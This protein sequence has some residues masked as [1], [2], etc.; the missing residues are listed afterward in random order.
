MGHPAAGTTATVSGKYARLTQLPTHG[1]DY[2]TLVPSEYFTGSQLKHQSAS[3]CTAL[4]MNVSVCLDMVYP[5][6]PS[7]TSAG[8]MD[9]YADNPNVHVV[10]LTGSSVKQDMHA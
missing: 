1:Q 7:A 8:T 2:I 3:P 4:Q 5:P 9:M 6:L 10:D